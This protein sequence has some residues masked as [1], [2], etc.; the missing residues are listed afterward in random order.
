MPQNY[1]KISQ[2]ARKCPK[3]YQNTSK[4]VLQAYLRV[5]GRAN[6]L[7]KPMSL[8]ADHLKNYDRS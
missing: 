1:P 8:G 5:D 6:L 2:N 3:I 4:Y 7:T